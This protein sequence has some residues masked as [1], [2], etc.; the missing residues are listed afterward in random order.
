MII[1]PLL[2]VATVT[3]PN[4]I[5]LDLIGFALTYGRRPK[6]AWSFSSMGSDG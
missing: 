1:S 3:F 4:D 6:D 5:E 2:S